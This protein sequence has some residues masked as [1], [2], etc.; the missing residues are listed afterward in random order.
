MKIVGYQGAGVAAPDRQLPGLAQLADIRRPPTIDAFVKDVVLVAEHAGDHRPGRVVV[1]RLR[2][3][4][5][6]GGGV[7]R[8]TAISILAQAINRGGFAGRDR[9]MLGWE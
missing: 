1:R 2:I 7:E 9:E 5:Q 3:S 8:E 4:G 6:S